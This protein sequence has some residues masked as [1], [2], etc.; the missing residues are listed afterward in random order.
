MTTIRENQKENAAG[1][2]R[3][4]FSAERIRSL[5]PTATLLVLYAVA[6]IAAPGYL[7]TAQIGSLLQQAAILGIV[8]IGQTLVILVGGID[9]SVGAVVTL[10]NLAAGAI[11]NGSDQNLPTAIVMALAIGLVI[12]LVN[13]VVIALLKVPDLVATLASMTVVTGVGYI[14]TNGSPRGSSSASLN[15]FVTERYLGILSSAV[16]LWIVLAG[17]TIVL[18]RTTASGRRVYAVGLSREASRFASI[19]STKV[20]IALYML[21]G[22]TASLAGLLLT[23]Y[24]GSSFLGSG[25]S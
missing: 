23:G 15:A 17:V 13:G 18:L 6:V 11:I 8:A 24:T 21:S 10:A 2:P 1:A 19:S 22:L 25:E 16:V 20:V 7:A 12:G 4:A 5:A 9:L 3:Q 14:V